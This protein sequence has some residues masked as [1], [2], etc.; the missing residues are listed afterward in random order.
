MVKVIG[1]GAA[2]CSA[3][4]AAFEAGVIESNDFLLLNTT[5]VDIKE[6]YHARTDVTITTVMI[7]SKNASKRLSRLI[8]SIL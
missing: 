2:G 7:E 4:I 8:K 3:T 5:N 1:C 6:E